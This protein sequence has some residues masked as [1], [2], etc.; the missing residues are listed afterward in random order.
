MENFSRKAAK[1]AKGAQRVLKNGRMK[2]EG[3]PR[4]AVIETAKSSL[5]PFASLCGFCDFAVDPVINTPA[6]PEPQHFLASSPSG[7]QS[8]AVFTVYAY[9]NCDTCRK[10]LKWL[11]AHEVP[12]QVK[13]IRE[14]PPTPAELK[15]ALQISGRDIRKLFN[16]SGADYRELG[17]KER[18]PTLSET[19]AIRMLSENGNLVKRPFL[20]GDGRALCGF[21]EDDWR[22]AL[23]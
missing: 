21:K 19:D 16:T 13:A 23:L 15:S 4:K 1:V 11:I 6:L 3:H 20:T 22:T 8:C 7:C 12:H 2:P 14:T 17:M 5:R 18:L 9:Q 10:A